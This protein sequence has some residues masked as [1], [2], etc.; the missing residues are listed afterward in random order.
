MAAISQCGADFVDGV[1]LRIL[2]GGDG[3]LYQ[4][5][6]LVV[7]GSV[8]VMTVMDIR[9][10]E[11][12][13]QVKDYY[14]LS[15]YG[16]DGSSVTYVPCDN[17]RLVSLMRPVLTEDEIK[18][19]IGRAGELPDMEWKP[20]NRSRTELFK[21]VLESGDRAAILVMIRSVHNAGLRRAAIGKKNFL[22]D[23]NFMKRAEKLIE[24][25]FSLSLGITAGEVAEI[26]KRDIKGV[27]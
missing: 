20:D 12:L 27:E 21:T 8:G 14:L 5:G 4:V 19:A 9:R 15:E 6:D 11:V 26:I 25:E 1:S 7:Y 22:T 3:L 13:G 23:E 16:R 24:A 18:A 17:E 10:E 2:N